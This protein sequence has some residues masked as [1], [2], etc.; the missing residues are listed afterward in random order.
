MT[1][2]LRVLLKNVL[3]HVDHFARVGALQFDELADHLGRR[4]VHFLDHSRNLPHD[5]GIVRHEKTGR[6][7][8]RENVDRAG[9]SLEIGRQHLLQ[10]LRVGVLETKQKADDRIT[11]RNVRDVGDDRHKRFARILPGTDHFDDVLRRWHKRDAVQRHAHLDNLNR[12]VARHVFGDENVH[13]ALDEIVHDQLLAGEL[14]VIM[15]DI[16]DVA[17][18][19]L[20]PGGW[21]GA[22]RRCGVSRRRVGGIRRRHTLQRLGTRRLSLRYLR[23]G[24][25]PIRSLRICRLRVRNLR[26][27]RRDVRGLRVP[28]RLNVHRFGGPR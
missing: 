14:F 18:G 4:H 17:V 26:I 10:L 19:K 16:N 8:D 21:R 12:L 27:C 28:R 3:Q 6:L 23:G 25:L 20:Q 5:V 24:P 9:S 1:R 11:G 2:L 7:R 13:L 22:R 15:Q